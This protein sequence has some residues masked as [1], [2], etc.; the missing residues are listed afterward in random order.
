MKIKTADFKTALTAVKP[1][2]AS[3]EIIEQSTCF[4]FMDETVFAYNDEI[5][6]VHP[7]KG[8][9]ITGVI[10]AEEL[11][12]F[13]NKIKTEEFTVVEQDNEIVMKAGRAKSGFSLVPEILLPMEEELAEKSKWK[14]L[15]ENFLQA[16]KFAAA[17][18]STDMSDAK[19][20]C[21]HVDNKGVIEA[22]NNFKMVVWKFDEAFP[23]QTTLIPADSIKQV[24]KLNATHVAEGKGWI[25]FKNKDAVIISCRILEE[26][27]MDTSD[28]LKQIKR[29]G[30]TK[31]TFPKTL[32]EILTKAEIFAKDQDNEGAVT[33]TFKNGRITVSAKNV[34]SWFKETTKYKG[35]EEFEFTIVSYLLRDILK[36]TDTCY[37]NNGMLRFEGESWMYVTSCDISE[38]E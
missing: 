14:A 2:L 33:L 30:A 18:A 13:L 35:D 29:K 6:I 36:E 17:S 32:P 23:M 19:L 5:C 7:L 37:L 31:I 38:Q 11:F 27:Y 24:V 25:H 28:V 1:A 15:P 8:M 20:T 9:E 12:K 34:N 22:S 4:A 3:K 10:Q 21:V 16:C 26:E